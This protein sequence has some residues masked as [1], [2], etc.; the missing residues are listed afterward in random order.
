MLSLALYGV[1]SHGR[2]Q[3]FAF[4]LVRETESADRETFEFV[5]RQFLVYMDNHVP[6]HVL[7]QR[8]PLTS[9]LY[10]GVKRVLTTKFSVKIPLTVEDPVIFCPYALHE[11]LKARFSFLQREERT[12]YQLLIALPFVMNETSLETHLKE[13]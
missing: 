11:D 6:R 7:M 3:I 8:M 1:N 4:C 2:N 9:A 13:L 12:L 5:F 10:Q